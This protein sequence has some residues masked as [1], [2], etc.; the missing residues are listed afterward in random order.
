MPDWMR[1][2]MWEPHKHVCVQCEKSRAM[3]IALGETDHWIE[4]AD[5]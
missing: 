3:V 1:R 5:D 4:S 2:T